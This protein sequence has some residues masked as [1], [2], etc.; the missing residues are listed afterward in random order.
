[1]IVTVLSIM[2]DL[3]KIKLGISNTFTNIIHEYVTT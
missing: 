3:V 1:M 2:K